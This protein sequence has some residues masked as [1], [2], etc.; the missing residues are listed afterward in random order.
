MDDFDPFGEFD[1][2]EDLGD[3]GNEEDMLALMGMSSGNK[4]SQAQ[5]Y[6]EE[7]KEAK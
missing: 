2:V 3:Y 6:K 7:K 5:I 1:G 4:K